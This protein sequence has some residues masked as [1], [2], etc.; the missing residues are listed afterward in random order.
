MAGRR[1][2]RANRIRRRPPAVT[3]PASRRPATRVL[4][5]RRRRRALLVV[6]VGVSLGVSHGSSPTATSDNRQVRHA[7][8][9]ARAFFNQAHPLYKTLI[10]GKFLPNIIQESA[11]DFVDDFQKPRHNR[12]KPGHRPLF[13]RFR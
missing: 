9:A 3:G 13:Q 10:A 1:P 11:V 12:R 7:H 4:V 5:G 2:R 8:L 6:G